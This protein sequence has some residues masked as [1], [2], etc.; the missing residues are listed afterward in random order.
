MKPG[1]KNILKLLAA[2]ILISV[3]SYVGCQFFYKK[4]LNINTVYADSAITAE[5]LVLSY[6][7]NEQQSN[8]TY[9]EKILEITGVVREVTFIN[10]RNTVILH[11][12][13]IDAGVICDMTD[14]QAARIKQLTK[15]QTIVVKGICKGFLKDVILINCILIKVPTNG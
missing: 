4:T 7:I 10:N 14:D 6:T 11:G 15:G 13:D 8:E 5:R 3:V 12:N 2:L 1:T 9:R